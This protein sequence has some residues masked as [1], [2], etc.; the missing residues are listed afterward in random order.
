MVFDFRDDEPTFSL[1]FVPEPGDENKNP[2][3]ISEDFRRAQCVVAS[4]Q[5]SIGPDARR[6][7]ESDG[8]MTMNK[9][10]ATKIVM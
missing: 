3:L 10:K 6:W 1:P 8:M 2:N 7:I 9:V 5:L 4:L